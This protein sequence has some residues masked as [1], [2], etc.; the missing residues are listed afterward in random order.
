MRRR[1]HGFTRIRLRVSSCSGSNQP[2]AWTVVRMKRLGGDGDSGTVSG[3]RMMRTLLCCRTIQCIE[4]PSAPL[5]A[6]EPAV[7]AAT[8]R[9]HGSCRSDPIRSHTRR[10]MGYFLRGLPAGYGPAGEE[11]APAL[12]VDY[13]VPCRAFAFRPAPMTNAEMNIGDFRGFVVSRYAHRNARGEFI[14]AVRHMV[15]E[16]ADPEA[17][18]E[19]DGLR[20]AREARG[21][22]LEYERKI[23]REFG[24]GGP[25]AAAVRPAMPP[26]WPLG[27]RPDGRPGAGEFY[28]S[29]GSSRRSRKTAKESGTSCGKKTPLAHETVPA[30]FLKPTHMKES[31]R[32]ARAGTA[33]HT[34]GRHGV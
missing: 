2:G 9:G 17:W 7:P 6:R 14:R 16:G 4:I 12:P 10:T 21:L 29:P 15:S 33:Y 1:H 23:A 28:Q 34:P 8:C 18:M 20:F 27:G 11:A 32:L 30:G 19:G 22:R 5:S 24:T 25:G 26:P 13:P 31:P 3:S